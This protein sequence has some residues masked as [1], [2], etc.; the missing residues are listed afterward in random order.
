MRLTSGIGKLEVLD[1]ARSRKYLT[2]IIQAGQLAIG[3]LVMFGTII[4][5]KCIFPIKEWRERLSYWTGPCFFFFSFLQKNEEKGCHT[6]QDLGF[7]LYFLQK[8]GGKGCHC[9]QDLV[10]HLLVFGV[11]V[12]WWH[13]SFLFS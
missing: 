2:L 11:S 4:L 5:M 7:Y 12:M 6:G 13:A 8:N 9:G 3:A 10:D 1:K